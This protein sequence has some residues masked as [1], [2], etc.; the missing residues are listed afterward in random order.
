MGSVPVTCFNRID[1]R[2]R[3]SQERNGNDPLLRLRNNCTNHLCEAGADYIKEN[4][5]NN[6]GK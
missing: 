5:E 1:K 2:K 4:L 6:A 3:P